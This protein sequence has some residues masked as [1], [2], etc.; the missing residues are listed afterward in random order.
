[1]TDYTSLVGK[2]VSIDCIDLDE[3]VEGTLVS[4]DNDK[5]GV[6]IQTEYSYVFIPWTEIAKIEYI[7][8]PT[9]APED[10][11]IKITDSD[12]TIA[13]NKYKM[14]EEMLPKD[15]EINWDEEGE[16]GDFTITDDKSE[17]AI[18]VDLDNDDIT[19][20]FSKDFD[21]SKE[22]AKKIGI[23]HIERDYQNEDN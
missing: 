14:A 23:K 8:N 9:K 22:I 18:K 11:N 6:F 16:Y 13:I 21:L 5:N 1:M 15:Y 20:L 2:I 19:V 12:E 3:S 10:T 4:M 17:D 7:I